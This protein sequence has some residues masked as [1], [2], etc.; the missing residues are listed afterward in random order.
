MGAGWLYVLH[1]PNARQSTA[2][3]YSVMRCGTG[4]F[5]IK[6]F[7]YKFTQWRSKKFH[8]LGLKNEEHSP[9]MFFLFTRKLYLKWRKFS[10]NFIARVRI[11][12][13]CFETTLNWND[14]FPWDEVTHSI[15]FFVVKSVK[16]VASSI[17]TS[18]ICFILFHC[19]HKPLKLASLMATCHQVYTS[20]PDPYNLKKMGWE[21]LKQKKM[22]KMFKKIR[23]KLINYRNSSN[24]SSTPE[25]ELVW[26]LEV[27][28][29]WI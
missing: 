28:I 12:T 2:R 7:R 22:F 15:I 25:V 4:R 1:F 29:L 17:Q 20:L 10:C 19:L 16:L 18:P 9:K 5:D 27:L 6:S 24:V 8:L 11:K 21:R 23:Y 13:T 3:I 26:L 14:R